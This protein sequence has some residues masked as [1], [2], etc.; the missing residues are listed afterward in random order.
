MSH[1][2]GILHIC[3]S[4]SLKLQGNDLFEWQSYIRLLLFPCSLL[5]AGGDLGQVWCFGGTRP[6]HASPNNNMEKEPMS[7]SEISPLSK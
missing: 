1:P 6:E 3:I 2:H 7:L 5:S 4:H